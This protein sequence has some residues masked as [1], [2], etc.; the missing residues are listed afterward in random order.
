M[1]LLP[2]LLLLC[3]LDLFVLLRG[4]AA[5]VAKQ[6]FFDKGLNFECSGCGKCCRSDGEV[7]LDTEEYLRI[8][9]NLR[10]GDDEFI[11]SYIGT[12][13]IN[14][15]AR[16]N[17]ANFFSC[18]P[19]CTSVDII[20]DG[21]VSLRNNYNDENPLQGDSCIFLSQSD[22]KTCTIYSCRPVQCST[23]PWW[24]RLLS[25]RGSWDEEAVLSDADTGKG[26]RWSP[27]H[28]G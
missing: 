27:E 25:S 28:G 11:N 14:H 12:C 13:N 23:Y 3:L 10:I 5:P 15:F 16:S 2:L 22:L 24:P 1:T 20:A 21:W 26:R 17:T 19:R 9:D 8:R 7:W 4:L 18:S 6:P